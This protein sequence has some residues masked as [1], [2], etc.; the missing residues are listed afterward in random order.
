MTLFGIVRSKHPAT[1]TWLLGAVYASTKAEKRKDLWQDLSEALTVKVPCC[2]VGDFNQ[3][4]SQ[5]EK[6]GGANF[7]FDWRVRDFS[8]F[9]NNN[10]LIHLSTSGSLYTWCNGPPGKGSIFKRL[11][12]GLVNQGWKDLFPD[13]NITHLPRL[14]S[15]HKP[16]LIHC[17]PT[18]KNTS[19]LKIFG[20]AFQHLGMSF[21]QPGNPHA[22]VMRFINYPIA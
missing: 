10:A 1:P 4:L 15:D 21:V 8:N 22:K 3:I 9:I 16:L 12:R 7:R 5:S 6:L 20:Y 19:T 18:V 13:A 14:S 17:Y 2:L 11:D